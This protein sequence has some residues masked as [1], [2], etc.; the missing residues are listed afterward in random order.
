[1]ADELE[2]AAADAAA[3]F[4]AVPDGAWGA[5]AGART[6]PRSPWSHSAATSCTISSTTLTT[7]ARDLNDLLPA[8]RMDR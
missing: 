5:R 3:L 7:S 8:G 1:M 4:A 6:A 2:S